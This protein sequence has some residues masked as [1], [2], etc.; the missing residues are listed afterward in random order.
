MTAL[1]QRVR[2]VRHFNRFYTRQI[3][4]LQE[5]MLDS[6]FSLA[7]GRVLY[8]LAHREGATATELGNGLG[9]D[10]GYLSRILAG[11]RKRGLLVSKTSATDRRAVELS[12]NAK[13]RAAFALL[14][15]GS[16]TQVAGLLGKLAPARQLQ[17]VESMKTIESL[18]DGEKPATNVGKSAFILRPHRPGDMGWVVHR[19]AV[20]YAR[21][22]GWDGTFEALVAEI[23]AAFIRNFDSKS[24]R[25][26]IAE[27]DDEIIGCVFLV[28]KSRAVG[29]LRMLLV[30]PGA[31]GL[32]LGNRL[33]GECIRFARECGYRKLVLWTNDILH[34]ARR[35]YLNAG[36]EL[37]AEERHESFG[38]KLV[39]QTW[40][41]KL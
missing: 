25:C 28:R 31:R 36:F 9:L 39:G 13:G 4:V 6:P 19:H 11:F 20:L 32:G 34:A 40:E 22:Y 29:Q 41:L 1:S 18:L 24:E 27:R 16:N 14:N 35:I 7:Q 21:E 2:A 5:S 23:T 38:Q 17:L 30:E 15:A 10:A 37:V 3:G 8:E 12:L 26:W 33:V